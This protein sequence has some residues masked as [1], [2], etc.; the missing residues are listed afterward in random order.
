A[1]EPT[2]H[3]TGGERRQTGGFNDSLGGN[4]RTT[5]QRE[6]AVQDLD[7]AEPSS[8]PNGGGGLKLAGSLVGSGAGCQAGRCPAARLTPKVAANC[9]GRALSVHVRWTR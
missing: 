5:R 8:G 4:A 2:D 1:T 6:R 7:H 3:P 9:C